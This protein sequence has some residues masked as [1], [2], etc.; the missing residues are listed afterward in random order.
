MQ[1][2]VY[3]FVTGGGW[4][5]V[6]ER[7]L[8]TGALLNEGSAMLRALVS[9]LVRI[10]N[11]CALRD[12][13]C[14]ISIDGAEVQSVSSAAEERR[15][16]AESV[17]LADWTVVIAPECDGHLLARC[18]WVEQLGGRLLSPG[19]EFVSIA[20]DKHRTAEL[21]ASANIPVPR[22]CPISDHQSPPADFQ[23]PAVLKPHDGAG[24]VDVRLV[25]NW[26][27]ARAAVRPGRLYRLEE[28][29]SGWPA[30][31]SVLSGPRYRVVLPASRQLL[32]DDGR[33]QYLGG[34]TPLPDEFVRRAEH[35]AQAVA[36]A[37][38][39]TVGYFGIDLVFGSASDGSQDLVI[40]VNP[41]MTTSY[42]GLRRIAQG[43]LAEAML[44]TACG[45]PVD[46]SFDDS[47]VQFAADAESATV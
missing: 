11:V 21:L 42:L 6:D 22:G 17:Q 25:T 16:F 26:S 27:E 9:D 28:F 35:R 1:F 44:L 5:N 39:P 47:P 43:N 13:R 33:F 10:G 29:H 3:E 40:E 30:S 36:A 2:F 34:L 45:E 4:W 19:S 7:Q 31:V 38:P 41:R 32:S 8:P 24:S 18:Q 12:V 14:S 20:G 23:F 46:L 15:R 37:M